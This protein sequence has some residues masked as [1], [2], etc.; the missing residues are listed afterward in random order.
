MSRRIHSIDSKSYHR[1][2]LNKWFQGLVEEDQKRAGRKVYVR[3]QLP[4]IL[5]PFRNPLATLCTKRNGRVLHQQYGLK[6]YRYKHIADNVCKWLDEVFLRPNELADIHK[7]SLVEQGQRLKTMVFS[8]L[9]DVRSF[10]GRLNL[11]STII[12]MHW[13]Q[14]IS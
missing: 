9:A 2:D 7:L 6:R 10:Q 13:Y 3:R 5:V 1:A 14:P 12:Q 8:S 4:Q 11:H